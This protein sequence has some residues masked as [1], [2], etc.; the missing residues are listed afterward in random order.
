MRRRA[1][2]LIELLVVIAIISIL[3]GVLL[4]ALGHARRAARATACLVNLR[5]LGLAQQA[6]ANDYDGQLVNYDPSHGTA[7]LD[8]DLS[9]FHSLS[10]Y[11]DEPLSLKSPL[12]ASPHWPVDRYGGQGVP[13]PGTTARLRLTSYGLNQYLTP[14]PPINVLTGRAVRHDNLWR[15]GA[16]ARLAQFAVMVFEGANAGNDH[17]HTV[18]WYLPF[19]PA[20]AAELAAADVETNAAAGARGVWESRSNYGFLDGHAATLPF[21]EVYRDSEANAFDPAAAAP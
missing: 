13:V 4:P 3:L 6:Y 17:F 2:T 9:W 14:D 7:S 5:S 8:E 19:H 11:Y 10:A 15:I 16:P 1:F 21:S 18:N 12:D 20:G